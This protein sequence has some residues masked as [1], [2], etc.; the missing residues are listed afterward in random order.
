[1]EVFDVY[2]SLGQAQDPYPLTQVDFFHAKHRAIKKANAEAAVKGLPPPKTAVSYMDMASV[3]N[4]D[5]Y[6]DVGQLPNDPVARDLIRREAME[7]I[8]AKRRGEAASKAHKE[9]M[10][11]R[12]EKS[13]HADAHRLRAQQQRASAREE[14]KRRVRE[15]FSWQPRIFNHS[16]PA[17]RPPRKRKH[18]ATAG[19]NEKGADSMASNSNKENS[20]AV[21]T[22]G[23]DIC[24][25]TYRR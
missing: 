18:A 13:L 23:P 2:Y 14:T 24:V 19:N 15:A 17:I 3:R 21:S 4:F 10:E 11:A 16:A 7:A 22:V 5:H 6:D 1:M 9:H 12:K 8:E 25:S 20:P